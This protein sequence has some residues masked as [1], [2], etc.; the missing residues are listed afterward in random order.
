MVSTR[1]VDPA[2]AEQLRAWDGSEGAYWA[3]HAERFEQALRDYDGPFFEAAAIAPTDHVLDIGCGTGGS[4]R[5]AA[6]RASAGS[7][8]GVDLSSAMLEVARRAAERE[9]STN[10]SFE[11]ADAQIHPFGE[12]AF[13]VAISRTGAMFFG[14]PHAAFTNIARALRPGGR[15]VLL[16]WQSFPRNEWVVEIM[17]ALAAGRELPAPPPG[18]PGPFSMAD[19]DRVHALLS[20]AGFDDVWVSGLEEQMCFGLDPDDAHRFVSGLMHWMLDGLD[21]VARAS[22]V[23]ALHRTMRAHHAA[24]GVTFGS[25][26][27]LVTARV[28]QAPP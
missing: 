13:D 4:T 10:V 14:D 22:A 16:V 17:G 11:Q 26:A 1:Q 8:L 18:A 19:P 28:R 15:L 20:S 7:V 25:A 12:V 6:R 23:D 9:G 21:D 2:N 5:A 27:W 3:A 24:Q